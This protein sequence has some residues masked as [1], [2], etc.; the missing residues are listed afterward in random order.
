MM[1]VVE[2]M[3]S[4]ARGGGA[5]HLLGLLPALQAR[6]HQVSA[7]CGEDG[8]L[9]EELGQR[10]IDCFPIEMMH[11]RLDPRVL[12]S[13]NRRMRARRP[14]IVHWHGT[15]AGFYGAWARPRRSIYTAHGLAYRKERTAARRALFL[16]A[17]AIACRAD[18]VI[19]VSRTDRDELVARGYVA[20][21][22]AHYV[23][24]ALRSERLEPMP[25]RAQARALLGLRTERFVV[26]TTS[27]L[28]TQKG[29]DVAL[30]AIASLPDV[31][32]IVAGDGPLRNQ[33]EQLGRSLGVDVQWLGQRSDIATVLSALDVFVLSS[34]WEG[35]PIALLE[36]MYCGLPCVATDTEGARELL[37]DGAGLLVPIGDSGSLAR[38]LARVRS[39]SDPTLGQRGR[40]RV[41]GRSFANMAAQVETIYAEA[42]CGRRRVEAAR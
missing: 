16:A 9:L 26:G 7:W 42:L 32:F 34:A 19:S 8:P 2:V 24:N 1:R 31:T 5:E 15:R 23:P 40:A 10:G 12:W 30:H 29:I 27:R 11:S 37:E 3:A 4:G 13:L 20:S 22:R 39:G 21:S 25:S 36:A 14:D 33:L 41:R 6:G 35:E 38:G 18:R 28:V 17:E